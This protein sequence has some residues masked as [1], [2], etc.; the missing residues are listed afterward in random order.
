MWTSLEFKQDLLNLPKAH[1]PLSPARLSLIHLFT[2]TTV[3]QMLQ[4]TANRGSNLLNRA[5]RD[6]MTRLLL[7]LVITELVAMV[8]RRD[9]VCEQDVLG[10]GV[11]SRHLDLVAGEHP[12][13]GDHMLRCGA[14]EGMAAWL[15]S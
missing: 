3:A 5:Q 6:T 9:D 11:H 7:P 15:V 14:D 2:G 8:I 13:V 1:E 4:D 10:F 12:P